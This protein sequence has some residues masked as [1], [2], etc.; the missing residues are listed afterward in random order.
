MDKVREAKQVLKDAGFCVDVLWH[1]HD[2]YSVMNGEV[3]REEAE[4]ILRDALHETSVMD[5]VWDAI[6]NQR[7]K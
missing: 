4:R 1:I 7:K 3:T 2:V 5:A 6:D